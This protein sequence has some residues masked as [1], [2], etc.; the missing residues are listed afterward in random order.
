MQMGLGSGLNPKLGLKL[1]CEEM[2]AFLK[3][4]MP[5]AG[6]SKS[7]TSSSQSTDALCQHVATI[8][9]KEEEGAVYKSILGDK[10]ALFKM[11]T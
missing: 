10:C 2:L 11:R 5:E 9:L 8:P 7:A 6:S 3:R 4:H 1:T